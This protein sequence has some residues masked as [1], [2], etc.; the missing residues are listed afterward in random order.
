[1][2]VVIRYTGDVDAFNSRGFLPSFSAFTFL[3]LSSLL[4]NVTSMQ[5]QRMTGKIE[6]RDY[7]VANVLTVP[8]LINLYVILIRAPVSWMVLFLPGYSFPLPFR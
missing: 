5:S 8:I 7:A 2:P 4:D 6:G 1:M 3:R